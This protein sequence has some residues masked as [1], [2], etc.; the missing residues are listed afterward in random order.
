MTSTDQVAG[1]VVNT[2]LI[3]ISVGLKELISR[4]GKVSPASRSLSVTLASSSKSLPLIVKGCGS[5]EPGTGSGSTL[6]IARSP[7]A[8][9]ITPVLCT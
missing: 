6:E 5:S 8:S 4:L 3:T 7:D 1:S 2:G 9:Q